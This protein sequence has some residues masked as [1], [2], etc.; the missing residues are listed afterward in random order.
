MKRN[1]LLSIVCVISN[2]SAFCQ[3][4]PQIKFSGNASTPAHALSIW[5]RK[6]G[7]LNTQLNKANDTLPIGN[8]RLAAMIQGGVESE[9]IQINEESLW[10]GGPGGRERSAG[11]PDADTEYN[12]GY[13]AFGPDHDAIYAHFKNG[14]AKGDAG[15]QGL[16]T[17][18]LEG[19]YNGYGKYKNFGFLN[20]DYKLQRGETQVSDYRRELDMHDGVAR[21]TYRIGT[22]TYTREYLASYPGNAIAVRIEAKGP[23]KVNL[24][25]SVTPGQ[26]DGKVSG[27]AQLPVVSARNGIIALSGGLK[28]NGLLYAAAF[29]VCNE[30]GSLKTDEGKATVS[31]SGADS[32]TIY[33]S[34]GTDYKNEY[35]LPSGSTWFEKLTYRTGESLEQVSRR[36]AS[37]LA[38]ELD[39]KGFAAFKEKHIADHASLFGRVSLDLGGTNSVPTDEALAAYRAAGGTKGPQFQMLETLLY[40]Y[41]RDML[42]ASSREGSLPANLQGKWNPENAPPWS[43]DYHTNINLQMNYWP[44]GGAN[45]LETMEPLQKFVLSQTVTGRYTAQRYQY[46]PTTPLNDWKL[47]GTGWNT[48]ISTNI[49]GRTA[50]GR[51]WYWGWS[52]GSN[53]FLSQNLYQ[54][55]Q[56]G[57]DKK[58]FD[59]DYWPIIREAALMWTKA[60]RKPLD[61]LWAG[62]YVVSPSYSPEHGPLTVAVAYE[63]QLVWELFTLALDCMK[64]LGHEQTDA[65]LKADIEEKLANLYSPVNIGEYGQIMEWTESRT[66]FDSY[67]FE[68]RHMSQLVGFYPGTSIANGNKDY[69]AAAVKTLERRGD[70][71]T[72]WS[73][74]WKINLW[75]RA[76]DGNHAYRLI[77]NLFKDNLA[78]NMFDLHSG[79]GFSTDGFY[80]QIDGNFGYTAGVQEMLVQSH[81]G[82]LDLLPA[83]PSVWAKGSVSGLRTIGGHTLDM[84]WAN[85]KLTTAKLKAF[86]DGNI[87]LRSAAFNGS[88]VTVNGAKAHMSGSALTIHAKKGMEYVIK[89]NR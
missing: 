72:G 50:P 87:A 81:L 74:G 36:V 63:Q 6:P 82:S 84:A 77:Q 55:L 40:Q 10:S 64:Q 3:D 71:A 58:T 39:S 45:L 27:K 69:H 57:G 7:T 88:N 31:V 2:V 26:P 48:H 33:F 18:M 53:A 34:L 1:S 23:G 35:S 75:A 89:I 32:A 24:D 56:Y 66:D 30:G 12:F 29:R 49:Y 37:A 54:Y 68:H 17:P 14:A 13:N 79:I 11:N 8:G 85:S 28:D 22:T 5:Y 59:R 70:G 46:P 78:K 86:A 15:H 19:N 43:A 61:G 38:P 73:M 41:G 42:I 76:L 9:R 20:L 80:F 16:Y 25:V 44:A 47:P 4:R 65:I 60:L 52:P 83:L 21:V 67:D 62:K 51:I